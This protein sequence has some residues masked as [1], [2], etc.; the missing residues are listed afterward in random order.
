[1][2]TLRT[3]SNLAEAELLKSVLAGSGIP[4]F[5]PDENSVLWGTVIGGY[6][7]QVDDADADRGTEVLR[8]AD[9]PGSSEPLG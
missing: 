8:Q 1:M 5:V 2:T 6:R 7:V 9:L 4:A 3:C